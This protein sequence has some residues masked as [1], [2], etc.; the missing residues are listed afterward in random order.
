MPTT[1]LE[2]A[3]ET[4]RKANLFFLPDGQGWALYRRMET[5]RIFVGRSK[6][7]GALRKLISRCARTI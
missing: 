3:A 1:A 6:T 7:E 5:R 2:K 4:A